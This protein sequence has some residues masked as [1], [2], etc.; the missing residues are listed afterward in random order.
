MNKKGVVDDYI[1]LFPLGFTVLVLLI[2]AISCDVLKDQ[3]RGELFTYYTEQAEAN[4]KLSL[5]L[6]Q[7]FPK[8]CS[9]LATTS[10]EDGQRIAQET[11][12]KFLDRYPTFTSSDLVLLFL[13]QGLKRSIEDQG[14]S[15]PLSNPSS[16]YFENDNPA[17][18]YYADSF[19]QCV[20]DYDL[21]TLIPLT[22]TGS[23]YV[24]KFYGSDQTPPEEG[25]LYIKIPSPDPQH[26]GWKYS[27]YLKPGFVQPPRA[28]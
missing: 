5:V 14:T 1:T 22:A 10:Q 13:H 28:A 2:I 20:E 15:S 16:S 23:S 9:W 17:L 18:R 25:F 7:P 27:Y 12:K 3:Q 4:F 19:Y 6:Q 21:T 8:D 26:T 24:K 11:L